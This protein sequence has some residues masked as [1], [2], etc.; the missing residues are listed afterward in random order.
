MVDGYQFSVISF[1]LK[2]LSEEESD[3][4]RK[5]LW[6]FNLQFAAFCNYQFAIKK[7]MLAKRAQTSNKDSST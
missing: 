2:A 4:S 3:K 6:L 5:W 1:Q 7:N